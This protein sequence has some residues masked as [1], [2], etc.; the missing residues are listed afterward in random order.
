MGEVV[1]G[2][3]MVEVMVEVVTEV[4]MVV[5]MEEVL[6]GGHSIGGHFMRC[7]MTVM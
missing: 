3:V 5:G 2:E 4:D 6:V 1:M 7:M